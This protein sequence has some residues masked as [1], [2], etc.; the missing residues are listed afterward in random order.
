LNTSSI[1]RAVLAV[2]VIRPNVFGEFK[3]RAGGPKLGW[4][5]WFKASARNSK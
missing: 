1:V 3:S 5:N 2:V 4:F